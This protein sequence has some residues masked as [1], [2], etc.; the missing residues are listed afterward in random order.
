MKHEIPI[1]KYTKLSE[2]SEPGEYNCYGIIYDASFPQ[3]QEQ[4]QQGASKYECTIKLIDENIN[5]LN[6]ADVSTFNNNIITLIIKSQFKEKIP[7]IHTIGDI[8]RI[9]SGIYSHKN[10][11][12][13][14]LQIA[15]TTKGQTNASWCIFSGLISPDDDNNKTILPILSSKRYYQFDTEDKIIIKELRNFIKNKLSIPKSIC[16]PM[17]TA[18]DKRIINKE[19]DTTVKVNYKTELDDKYIYYVQDDTDICELQTNKYFDFIHVGDIIR[20]R[21][22]RFTEKNILSTNQFSNILIIPKTLGYYKEFQEKIKEQKIKNDKDKKNKKGINNNDINTS[23]NEPLINFEEYISLNNPKINNINYKSKYKSNIIPLNEENENEN[24]KLN[25]FNINDYND[26]S[27]IDQIEKKIKLSVI[28][29]NPNNKPKKFSQIIRSQEDNIIEVQIIKYHPANLIKC[30]KYICNKCKTN[31]SIENDFK[32]NL[33]SRFICPYCESVFVPNFYYN[34][35]FECIEKKKA[36]KIIIL[37]LNSYDG[38]G[39]SIFGVMPTN[40]NLQNE[41]KNKLDKILNELIESKGFVKLKIRKVY[42]NN[43]G[44]IFR[45]VGDYTNK[46]D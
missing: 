4:S 1:I 31:S 13:I 27:M 41:Q 21:S 45:I 29:F 12:N 39:E 40:F 28:D 6:C 14:Y 44:I 42:L 22:Y 30:V 16:F 43:K 11:K 37:H 38:E 25:L 15:T 18:L 46:V 24:K 9:H 17:E 32:A 8:I 34:M 26:S 10:K 2:L 20:I 35:V 5:F 23:E 19:N 3:I 7:Y 33:N 36:D